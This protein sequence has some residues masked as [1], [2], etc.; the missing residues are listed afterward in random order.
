MSLNCHDPYTDRVISLCQYGSGI[1]YGSVL[2]NDMA[3]VMD[4][5]PFKDI[6]SGN[7]ALLAKG[8]YT[9]MQ[10]E[11]KST[12]NASQ[13]RLMPILHRYHQQLLKFIILWT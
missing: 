6:G 2:A 5:E 10:A 13:A 12:L 7:E 4:L 11:A 3:I 9:W 8:Q 1:I